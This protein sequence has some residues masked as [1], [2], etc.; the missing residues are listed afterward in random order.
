MLP[1]QGL[2]VLRTLQRAITF[3]F[4][5]MR[6]LLFRKGKYGITQLRNDKLYFKI[7]QLFNSKDH[8]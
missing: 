8:T 6:K 2:C 7:T 1:A 4:L 5:K 3:P